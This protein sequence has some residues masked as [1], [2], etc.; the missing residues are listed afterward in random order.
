MEPIHDRMQVV[1]SEGTENERLNADANERERLCRP[2]LDDG[3]DAYKIST[4]VNN[5]SNEYPSV[6]ET[7]GHE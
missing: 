7:L 5:P 3:L 1:L 2:Y 6:I 4:R